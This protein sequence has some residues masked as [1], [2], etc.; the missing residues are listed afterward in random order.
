M[1]NK[2]T[3]DTG[4]KWSTHDSQRGC[5]IFIS[6]QGYTFEIMANLLPFSNSFD[7]IFGLYYI[8]DIEAKSNFSKL[9]FKFKNISISIIPEKTY[10]Y[11]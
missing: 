4:C 11:Q 1:S 7:F 3:T 5:Q 10:M 8:T 2:H 9:E 6:F